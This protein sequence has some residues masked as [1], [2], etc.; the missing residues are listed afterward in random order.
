M[1]KKEV[2]SVRPA[3]SRQ[4]R[5]LILAETN[6]A[7][8]IGQR[9]AGSETTA[10]TRYDNP[11]AGVYKPARQPERAEGNSPG[12]PEVPPLPPSLPGKP[13]LGPS[14]SFHCGRLA[15]PPTAFHQPARQTQAGDCFSGPA[16]QTRGPVTTADR[17]A[18]ERQERYFLAPLELPARAPTRQA[19]PWSTEEEP[20]DPRG[21]T[22][23]PAHDPATRGTC[24]DPCPDRDESIEEILGARLWFPPL[25][26]PIKDPAHL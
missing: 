3:A 14:L 8:T 11:R 20:L 7:A 2:K 19:K 21:H 10:A 6:R 26:S 22:P 18:T 23:L 24:W 4:I 5:H 25:L 17:P 15:N 1:K 13:R 12:K 9:T 16:W